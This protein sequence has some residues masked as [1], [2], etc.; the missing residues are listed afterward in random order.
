MRTSYS[1]NKCRDFHRTPSKGSAYLE[2][3]KITEFVKNEYILLFIFYTVYIPRGHHSNGM[4]KLPSEMERKFS[5][6]EDNP[7]IWGI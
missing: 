1:W 4:C 3:K 6:K 2:Q 7:K 5:P